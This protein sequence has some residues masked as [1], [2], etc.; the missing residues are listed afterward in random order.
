[1]APR[2]RF[3]AHSWAHHPEHGGRSRLLGRR[4]RHTANV[5]D[6][7]SSPI[8]SRAV[9]LLK[10]KDAYAWRYQ[11]G[12]VPPRV[13]RAHASISNL[14]EVKLRRVDMK[15]LARDVSQMLDIYNDAWGDSWGYVPLTPAEASRTASEF[16]LVANPALTCIVDIDGV[17]SAFAYALP[18]LNEAIAPLGGKL[19]TRGVLKAVW[20]VKFRGL[21]TARLVGLGVRHGRSAVQ[22]LPRVRKKALT[23]IDSKRGPASGP[24]NA[25]TL[26]PTATSSAGVTRT[27]DAPPLSVAARPACFLRFTPSGV[28]KRL[29]RRVP[30]DAGCAGRRALTSAKTRKP[31]TA[32]ESIAPWQNQSTA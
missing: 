21:S 18:N 11:T 32:R 14:P 17:P 7:T 27:L 1:M 29:A 16:R 3:A 13:S 9:G 4:L 26:S 28:P 30:P 2:P 20:D 25:I 22:D 10:A 5:T 15:N 31:K 6:G 12:N 23:S 24:S 8:S 19:L